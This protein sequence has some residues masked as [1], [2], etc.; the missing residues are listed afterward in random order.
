MYQ[1]VVTITTAAMIAPTKIISSESTSKSAPLTF[2]LP[3]PGAEHGEAQSVTRP[4]SAS[5]TKDV[6]LSPSAHVSA[7]SLDVPHV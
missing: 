1:P 4:P 3:A 7:R 6:R 5:T 2:R